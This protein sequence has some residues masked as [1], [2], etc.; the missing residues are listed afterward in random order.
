MLPPHLLHFKK[1]RIKHKIHSHCSL[2]HTR[3]TLFL[4]LFFLPWFLG[5]QAGVG[6][7][8]PETHPPNR[9]GSRLAKPDPAMSLAVTQGGAP[10]EPSFSS[11]F[12]TSHLLRSLSRWTQS[13]NPILMHQTP[14]LIPQNLILMPQKSF[15]IQN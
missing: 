4:F 9:R 11:H 12:L 3:N 6:L 14:F 2:S 15:L 5:E 10:Q 7:K 8:S 1:I 13:Q